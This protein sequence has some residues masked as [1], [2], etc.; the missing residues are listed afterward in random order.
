MVPERLRGRWPGALVLAL[1]A[2]L[3]FSPVCL[4]ALSELQRLPGWRLAGLARYADLRAQSAAGAR[5]GVALPL[6]QMPS[7][8]FAYV[9]GPDPRAKQNRCVAE[10]FGFETVTIAEPR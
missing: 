10:Y 2:S 7:A 4:S 5:T 3:F 6:P 9:L 1:C 8:Y